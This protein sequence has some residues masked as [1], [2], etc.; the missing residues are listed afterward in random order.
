MTAALAEAAKTFEQTL[1]ELG[2]TGKEREVDPSALGRRAALLAASEVVWHKHLGPMYSSKQVREVMGRG[3]R[4]SVSELAKRGRLIALPEE[5]RSPGVP[6]L[7]VRTHG[8]ATAGA[9][10]DP[11][12]LQRGGRDAVHG[13]VLVRDARAAAAGE[14][15]G[16]LA[17]SRPP[18]RAGARGGVA[19][20][21]AP[22]AVTLEP[23]RLPPDDLSR[24]PAFGVDR[25]RS[26]YR[27]HRTDAGPWWF[28]GDGSGRFDLR[29]GRARAT[30]PSRR[31]APSSRSSESRP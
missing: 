6:R 3:T 10:A 13:R 17:A 11:R 31:S 30:S 21:A 4:Q 14:D 15:A 24:F 8:R 19:V 2:I 9:G 23:A 29:D 26:L 27:I 5:G 18:G 7:P 25:R 16:R 12:D 1:G 20:R 28:S 22:A